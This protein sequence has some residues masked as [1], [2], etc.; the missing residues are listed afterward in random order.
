M[1]TLVLLFAGIL[2]NMNSVMALDLNLTTNTPKHYRYVQPITFVEHGIEFSVFPDGNFDYEFLY[3]EDYYNFNTRRSSINASYSG[4]RVNIN[5][6]STSPNRNYIS[7]DRNGMI[8]VVGNVPI[9]YDRTGNVT[10]IGSVFIG[11]GRGRNNTL[12]QV[13]GLIV[14]YN[15]WGQIVS[16]RGYINIDNRHADYCDVQ[17]DSWNNNMHFDNDDKYYYYKKNGKVKKM[18]KRN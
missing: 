1:K 7:R 3:T 14:N 5:Y 18:K 8:R 17:N 2:L 10:Q 4:P 6:T 15:N 12:N 16:T 11:Y 13:G 9:N